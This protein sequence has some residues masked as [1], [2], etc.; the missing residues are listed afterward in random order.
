[1]SKIPR[2]CFLSALKQFFVL[3]HLCY[4]YIPYSTHCAFSE[5]IQ[6]SLFIFTDGLFYL[7]TFRYVFFFAFFYIL[8]LTFLS[9]KQKLIAGEFH[10]I[11]SYTVFFSLSSNFFSA[12]VLCYFCFYLF[13]YSVNSCIRSGGRPTGAL[14]FFRLF[15]SIFPNTFHDMLTE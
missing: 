5:L 8:R 1:M 11:F 12:L 14:P 3:W 13:A 2:S 10:S 7:F 4:F 15:N 9:C 6:S